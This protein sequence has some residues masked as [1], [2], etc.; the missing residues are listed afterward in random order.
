MAEE[1]GSIEDSSPLVA[2]EM[3]DVGV[4]VED[5]R[6]CGV[7]RA[8]RGALWVAAGA[9]MF[10][11][12]VAATAHLKAADSAA[13]ASTPVRGAEVPPMSNLAVSDTQAT[14]TSS[15]HRNPYLELTCSNEYGAYKGKDFY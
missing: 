4:E 6:T 13:A 1:Y 5:V 3:E 15:T 14:R 7:G 8:R 2:R 10:L 9:A 11:S 12:G